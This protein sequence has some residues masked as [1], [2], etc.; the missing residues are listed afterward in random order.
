MALRESRT[1]VEALSTLKRQTTPAQRKNYKV[2]RIVR[3]VIK[4]K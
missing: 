1:K 2:V 4:H 3:Y